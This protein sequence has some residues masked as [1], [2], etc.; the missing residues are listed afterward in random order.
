MI[1]YVRRVLRTLI[2][3]STPST[4]VQIESLADEL[5]SDV[6]VAESYGL[7]ACPPDDVTEGVALFV[8]GQ[9]DHGLVLAWLDKTHRPR[10]L[11]KGEVLLYTSFGQRIKLNDQGEIIMTSQSGSTFSM[12]ANGDITAVPSSGEMHVT[13]KVIATGDVITPADVIAGAIHLKTHKHGGVTAGG[14]Q[15]GL[16][17]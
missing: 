2:D 7:T 10:N 9:S 14:A 3:T 4:Q 12:L 1:G 17:T 6:E 5:H 11:K 8:G 13:G 15:T 16:P